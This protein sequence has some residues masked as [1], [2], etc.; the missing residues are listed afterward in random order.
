MEV[1]NDDEMYL[2][3]LPTFAE[4][5]FLYYYEVNW[6]VEVDTLFSRGVNM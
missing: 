2:E 5:S 6:E 3:Y 1:K 4:E